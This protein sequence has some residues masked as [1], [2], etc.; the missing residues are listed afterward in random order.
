MLSSLVRRLSD[1]SLNY[2]MKTRIVRSLALVLLHFITITS[3]P[4]RAAT[5]TA[6]ADTFISEHEFHNGPTTAHGSDL[7]L[8]SVLGNPNFKTFPLIRFDLSPFTGQTVGSAQLELFV[9]LGHEADPGTTRQV[10]VYPILV[11][12]S[13]AAITYNSFGASPGLQFGVDVATSPVDVQPVRY[14][15][16]GPRYI[17]WNIPASVVQQWINSP[18]SNNGLLV[19]NNESINQRD[20]GFDSRE[21]A[22]A[23]RLTVNIVPEPTAATLLSATLAFLLLHR[24]RAKLKPVLS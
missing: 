18:T 14:P 13:E 10:S 7:L 15:G 17:A 20:L 12:W 2:F 6:V 5:I 4:L 24:N 22:N 3:S 23:P 16:P 21:A 8:Y 1:T 19:Y 9:S 11:P